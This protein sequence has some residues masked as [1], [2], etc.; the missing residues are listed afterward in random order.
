MEE[1][2]RCKEIDT[3]EVSNTGKIRNRR[4]GRVMRTTINAQG[5][6]CIQLHKNGQ[7][8]SRRLH[9]LI[10]DAFYDGEH[11]GLDVD[12]IDGNKLNNNVEN[13]EW[14][15]RKENTIRGYKNGL[16]YSHKKKPVR[17]I[18]TGQEFDSAK[19]CAD[20]LG[21]DSASVRKCIYGESKTCCGYRIEYI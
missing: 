9:R 12:H 21:V 16:S 18:D 2:K 19:A 11:D 8:Y 20:Y 1:W 14:C 3:Y 10:A 15:T 5:Y 17:I 13:L 6:E 4:T 7:Y